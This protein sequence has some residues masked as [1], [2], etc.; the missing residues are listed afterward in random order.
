MKI[1]EGRPFP[2]GATD[3]PG[4]INIAVVCEDGCETGKRRSPLTLVLE[5]TDSGK[6]ERIPFCD[7]ARV[8]QV[9]YMQLEDIDIHKYI[10][11]FEDS[12]GKRF[13]DPYAVRLKGTEQWG[14]F[15][16]HGAYFP[17]EYDWEDD[18]PLNRSYS[19][20]IMYMMHV[21]GFTK[22]ISS[23][24]K[25]RGTF[26]GIIEKLPYIT[27]LGINTIELMPVFEF[28]EVMDTEKRDQREVV[29]SASEELEPRTKKSKKINYWGFTDGYLFAP[30]NAYS[31]V[32]NGERSF[33]DMVKK[34]HANGIGVVV[35]L[36]FPKKYDTDYIAKC[37]VY[38]VSEL[39]VDGLRILGEKIPKKALTEN[40]YLKHTSIIFDDFEA[41]ITGNERHTLQNVA[42][43][44]DAFMCDNRKFLKGDADMLSAFVRHQLQ[45]DASI[46]RI[47]Y[48]DSYYGFTLNDMVTYDAKHNE[49]NGEGN[50]DGSD[51]NYSWNC[52]VEGKTRRK[53]IE[54]LR[55][56]QLRNAFTYLMLSQGVPEFVAGDEFRN[57]QKGNNNAYCQDNP[58]TYLNWNDL[59]RNREFYEFVRSIIALRKE[60]RVFHNENRLTLADPKSLGAPDVSIHGEQAWAPRLD[61]YM[62]HIGIM[63]NG[64]YAGA[65]G[66]KVKEKDFYIAYNMH[67]QKH[68][69]AL[70]KPP[71]G[72]RWRVLMNTESGFIK[73]RSKREET[74]LNV[75]ERSIVILETAS[76]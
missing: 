4:G 1:K 15:S 72:K 25:N 68:R 23:G 42:V 33:K 52:G 63:Y 24:I 35:Q 30:K 65:K 50:I 55:L 47:N 5:R 16:P 46:R 36:Y 11:S 41:E 57:S 45:N 51:Y 17:E 44:N 59:E 54:T 38:W 66:N 14:R 62:R 29:N 73:D 26:E 40:P 19:D 32:G 70:P 58:V 28:N 39:H 34:L 48:M 31:A 13:T 53:G 71:K 8:G 37:A 20:M 43:L 69:F 56:K 12:E 49:D 60:H 22:H 2:L 21:R 64:A 74:E 3:T 76:S 27:Q 7:N 67:W 6:R 75:A 10:Y 61:N 18:R 9:Y